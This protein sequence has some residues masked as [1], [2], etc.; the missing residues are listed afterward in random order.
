MKQILFLLLLIGQMMAATVEYIQSKGLKI[1]VIIE[2]DPRLPL[3]TIQLV[4]TNSGSIADETKAGVAKLSARMMNEG[5]KKMGASAF[6]DALEEKAIHI[7]STIGTE[8]FV[9]EMGALSEELDT[10]FIYL[11]KLL[12]DP[13]I[14]EQSLAKVKKTTIG[15]LSQKINDFDYVASNELKT[16][17]FEGSSLSYPASGTIESV[18]SIAL[19]DVKDFLQD[20]LVRSRLIFAVGGKVDK[21]DLLVKLQELAEILQEGKTQDIKRFKTSDKAQESIIKKDTKQAYIYFGAPFE[22]EVA[23][24]ENYK[25]RVAAHILGAGGFGSR[26]M[27]EI[28][29]KRGLAYSAYARVQVTKSRSYLSGY[30]QT[31]LESQE[32]AQKT[33][34]D[35]ISTFVKEGVSEEEL[36]QTKKFLLGSEPLRVETMSQRLGRS[37]QEFYRGQEIGSS[38]KELE[39]IKELSLEELNAFIK[40]HTEITDLSF[41][42]VTQ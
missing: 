36:E 5:S 31:K 42:I 3:A 23:S 2:E 17:L 8:T 13:N 14:T 30:L 11:K 29:V 24:Q 12:E 19:S 27:E 4:F 20:H 7:H 34:Q 16:L 35:V 25:A 10:A 9:M 28:R 32:E 18:E 41:A 37:F 33:V 40:K 26:L 15:A 39:K 1:P 6:A 38:Q 21:E 22:M